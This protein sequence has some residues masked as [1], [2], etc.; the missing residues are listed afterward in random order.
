MSEFE[1]A[2]KQLSPEQQQEAMREL[3]DST[4]GAE[5]GIIRQKLAEPDKPLTP[6]QQHVF[7]TK[8]L[9]SMVEHCVNHSS[10]NG[11]SLPGVEYCDQCAIRFG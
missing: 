3:L 5:A 9:P 1:K 4:D 8:I 10:C 6:K 11:F 2:A 7:D